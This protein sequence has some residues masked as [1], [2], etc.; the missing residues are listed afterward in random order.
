MQRTL[1]FVLPGHFLIL[2]L[3]ASFR[4]AVKRKSLISLICL[5]CSRT[6]CIERAS[7][8]LALPCASHHKCCYSTSADHYV[9]LELQSRHTRRSMQLLRFGVTGHFAHGSAGSLSASENQGAQ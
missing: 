4:R 3:L 6:E 2:T 9:L 1:N 7:L 8:E 5:G